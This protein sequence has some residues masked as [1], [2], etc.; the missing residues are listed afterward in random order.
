MLEVIR[1]Y[2]KEKEIMSDLRQFKNR[3]DV[4]EYVQEEQ[5]TWVIMW[6]NENENYVAQR[7]ANKNYRVTCPLLTYI[8]EGANITKKE[9]TK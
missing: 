6:D 1:V 7:I 9:V 8:L 3:I 4:L 2:G 5:W